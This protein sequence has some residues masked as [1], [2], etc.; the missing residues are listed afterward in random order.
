M[1]LE[2]VLTVTDKARKRV[3]EVRAGEQDGDRLALWIEIT[4][5]AGGD[6]AYDL[7]FDAPDQAH[8]GDA[9]QH[10]DDLTVVI[11]QASV[12]QFAERANREVSGGV[13]DAGRH[14]C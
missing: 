6:W 12:D 4:G 5:E 13:A 9:V 1:A 11:P 14:P 7:Y 8:E 10:G 2:P 3:L